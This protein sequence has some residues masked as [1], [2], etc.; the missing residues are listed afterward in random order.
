MLSLTGAEDPANLIGFFRCGPRQI[1]VSCGDRDFFEESQRSL[2]IP[3]FEQTKRFLVLPK[4]LS[5]VRGFPQS[6][7][8]VLIC[9]SNVFGLAREKLLEERDRLV[10]LVLGKETMD[11]FQG[12]SPVALGLRA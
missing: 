7:Q 8:L 3:L 11:P 6:S 2:E 9:R 5:L 1:G 4:R 12:L 10:I